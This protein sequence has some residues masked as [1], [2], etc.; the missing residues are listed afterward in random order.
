MIDLTPLEVR[1]KKGDFRKSMRGYEAQ[2]VDD[3][4]DLVADRLEQLVRENQSLADRVRSAETQTA[5]YRERERALTEALVTA[6]EMREEMRR[7]MEREVEL[8]MREVE[9]DVDAMRSSAAQMREREEENIRRLRAR[10]TQFVQSYRSFLERE[11]AEIGVMA[12]ALNLPDEQPPAPARKRGRKSESATEQ[13]TATFSVASEPLQPARQA[14]PAAPTAPIVAPI[15]AATVVP[16]A[17]LEPA[18]DDIDELFAGSQLDDEPIEPV[19]VTEPDPE[20]PLN[21]ALADLDDIFPP[22]QMELAERA[23]DDEEIPEIEL[24]DE[25]ADD[26]DLEEEEKDADADGWVSTLLE[27]KGD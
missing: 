22:A 1:K 17:D 13:I 3:F 21:D 16:V 9:A 10:Q 23:L 8:K 18:A 20:P 2:A 25:V 5:D 19:R 15:A 26:A 24:I 7:Q 14:A 6:Q 11:L 4:I 27:G 12:Q